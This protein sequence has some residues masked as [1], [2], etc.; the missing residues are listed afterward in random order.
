MNKIKINQRKFTIT[1][2][3]GYLVPS[4]GLIIEWR[5]ADSSIKFVPILILDGHI[6]RGAPRANPHTINIK[7]IRSFARAVD[8]IDDNYMLDNIESIMYIGQL[9]AT[10]F[11]PTVTSRDLFDSVLT[12]DYKSVQLS[13]GVNGPD[14]VEIIET[15]WDRKETDQ[16][17]ETEEDLEIQSFLKSQ[18]FIPTIERVTNLN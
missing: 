6:V 11:Y 10:E 15:Y 16:I 14:L 7:E 5:V 13:F 12:R 3:G 4:R 1:K 18:S 8:R 9:Y 17:G 2:E